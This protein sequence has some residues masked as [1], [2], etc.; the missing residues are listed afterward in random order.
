MMQQ[1]IED[2]LSKHSDE[3]MDIYFSMDSEIQTMSKLQEIQLMDH[4]AK[5]ISQS[6]N[7]TEYVSVEEDEKK[8][9]WMEFLSDNM[10][11]EF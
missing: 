4:A 8:K 3:L 2:V 7:V 9:I 5:G 6:E 1:K 10:A 11:R